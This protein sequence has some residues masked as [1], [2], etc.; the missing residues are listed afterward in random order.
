LNH[1][2]RKGRKGI[3]R[4]YL[5]VVSLAAFGVLILA[6]CGVTAT[7]TTRDAEALRHKELRIA[8]LD[9]YEASGT[10]E[11][12][13][14]Q[15]HLAQR[16][17]TLGFARAESDALGA[18]RAE[19]SAERA[20]ERARSHGAAAALVCAVHPVPGTTGARRAEGDSVYSD[21]SGRRDYYVRN[22]D[23]EA[24]K[25]PRIRASAELVD[26]RGAVLYRAELEM[27]GRDLTE[28]ALAAA[29]VDPI[30]D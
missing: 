2:T 8:V 9:V 29:L 17:R 4:K 12:G 13:G 25:G 10:V 24:S 27:D 21:A 19:W 26:A 3:D 5:L 11:A 28:A 22:L 18:P 16:L 15:M 1:E 23:G 6:G 14:L 7:V 30:G 20:A